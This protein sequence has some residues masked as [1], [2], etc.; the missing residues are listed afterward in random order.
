MTNGYRALRETV[1]CIDLSARGRIKVTGEDRARLL[2]AMTTNHVSGLKPGESCYAFFLNA[3]GRILADATILCLDD[4]FL[5]DV[6]PELREFLIEHLDRYII[7]DDV[8]LEDVTAITSE[9]SLEGPQAPL[10]SGPATVR[11]STTG[12]PG[13]RIFGASTTP[14]APLA[15]PEDV[16][17]VRHENFFP[18]FGDDFTSAHLPQE[19]GI[20]DALHF[21]KGCY[22]GQEIVER[23]RSRG[24]VNR[25]L[26]GFR[27]EGEAPVGK[28]A[29][30]TLEDN[31]VGE[32]TSAAYS[33][34]R[35]AT[36]AMGYIRVVAAKPGAV[37]QVAGRAAQVSAIKASRT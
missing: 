17:I 31:E 32:I 24:H 9:H 20:T 22:L 21:S 15:T 36:F 3:Q 25:I 10:G 8:V 2:H 14:E 34:V 29:K 33:P 1:A 30:V 18:R 19:T 13:I 35:D 23:V 12:E 7:A 11:A 37:V 28:G 6:E 5:L 4:H 16:Y 27:M 26:M